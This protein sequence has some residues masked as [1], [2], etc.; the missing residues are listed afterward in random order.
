MTKT[1]EVMF[2]SLQ[3]FPPRIKLAVKTI[4]DVPLNIFRLEGLLSL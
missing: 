3:K 2:V 1:N 4:L